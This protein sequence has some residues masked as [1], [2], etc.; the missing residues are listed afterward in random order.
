MYSKFWT[1]Y[2]IDWFNL[3]CHLSIV[4]DTL[5]ISNIKAYHICD[6]TSILYNL[7]AIDRS[8]TK[9]RAPHQWAGETCGLS[10]RAFPDIFPLV[11]LLSTFLQC[12]P[13]VS[14]WRGL[15]IFSSALSPSTLLRT[16]DP[17]GSYILD[18]VNTK[19]D[20]CFAPVFFHVPNFSV[21]QRNW[22]HWKKFA[23]SLS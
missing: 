18:L 20:F 17:F 16:F 21:W 23:V 12:V 4:I 3:T 7:V 22:T 5:W 19:N 2:K 10:R 14:W 13:K 8:V 9:A 11:C 6:G 15:G 1:Q